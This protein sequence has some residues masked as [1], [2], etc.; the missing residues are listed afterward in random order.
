VQILTCLLLTAVL[1]EIRGLKLVEGRSITRST[2][3]GIEP[4]S[5]WGKAVRSLTPV[6]YTTG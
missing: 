6:I 1:A 5:C 2:A 3:L 4:L